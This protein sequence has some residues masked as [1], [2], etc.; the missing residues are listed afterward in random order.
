V[1]F[2]FIYIQVK[3]VALSEVMSVGGFSSGLFNGTSGSPQLSLP[4]GGSDTTIQPGS[5]TGSGT[6]KEA[7]LNE[8]TT[9]EARGI[10]NEL[11]R[12]GANVGDGGTAD[13]IREELATGNPVSGRSHI[14][15]GRERLRQI[16]R[17]LQR[18]PDHPDRALL[19]RLRNDLRNALEGN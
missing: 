18:N 3:G 10:V 9:D 11:Y 12:E 1:E 7:L 14:Q 6:Q 2:L 13:A 8:A 15:K 16:E 5:N 19:E 4:N 17:I